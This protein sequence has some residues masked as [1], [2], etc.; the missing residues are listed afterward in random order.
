MKFLRRSLIALVTAA[1]V[2]SLAFAADLSQTATSVVGYGDQLQ[3]RLG[4]SVTAGMPVRKQSDGTFIAS[5]NA[6]SAGS[7]VDGIALTGGAS[8]QP[9]IYQK[10]GN[11]NLGATLSVGKIYV[12]SASGAISPVDDVVATDYIT[13][14]CVAISTSLCQMGI[15]NSLAQAA[16]DVT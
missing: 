8:G 12:L 3:G 16:A 14:L 9:F 11:I 4:G 6:T 10:G 15:V 7:Q 5:T 1:L 13:V 2:S